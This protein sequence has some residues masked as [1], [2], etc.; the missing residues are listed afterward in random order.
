[1]NKHLWH[2][3]L[4]EWYLHGVAPICVVKHRVKGVA[5]KPQVIK[6]QVPNWLT[7]CTYNGDGVLVVVIGFLVRLTV[8]TA[9][10]TDT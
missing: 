9:T 8:C 4:L 3:W 10:V 7:Y 5:S 6:P 2:A 1:M